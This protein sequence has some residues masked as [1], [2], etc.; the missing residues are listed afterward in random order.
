MIHVTCDDD[1][2]C[3]EAS[4]E[5]EGGH[6][7]A[8]NTKIEAIAKGSAA[9]VAGNQHTVTKLERG[10]MQSIHILKTHTQDCRSFT[11][12]NTPTHTTRTHT[13]LAQ[14]QTANSPQSQSQSQSHSPLCIS[15][16]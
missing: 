2:A 11:T 16:L 4:E 15:P 6:G 1:D 5:L 7:E 8:F 12:H 10:K 3:E 13:D 9:I 14:G